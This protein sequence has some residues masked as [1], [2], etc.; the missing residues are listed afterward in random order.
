MADAVDSGA[1]QARRSSDYC[2][3]GKACAGEGT[4]EYARRVPETRYIYDIIMQP[5]HA[6][7]TYL[8]RSSSISRIS[9]QFPK[10]DSDAAGPLINYKHFLFSKRAA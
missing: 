1:V 3:L 9:D 4:Y 10:I 7:A 5:G 6:V 2:Q 8:R